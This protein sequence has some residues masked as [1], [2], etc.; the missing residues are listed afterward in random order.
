MHDASNVDRRYVRF[1]VFELD[2]ETRELRKAGARV[3]LPEQPLQVLESLL[4]RPG[5]LVTRD[6]LRQRLWPGD[7]FVDFEHG[8]NAAVKRVRDVLGD[9]ADTPRFIET[10]PRRGYRFI[11]PVAVEPVEETKG[12]APL[13]TTQGAPPPRRT[14]VFLVLGGLGLVALATG[15]AW[16][17]EAPGPAVRVV[18]LTSLNG[19]ESEPTFSPDGDQ[20]AFTWT[21]END[22]N[23]DIYVTIV[24]SSDVR[25]LTTDPGEDNVPSWSPNGQQI[26]FVRA[27][28]GGVGRVHVM[29]ALGGLDLKVAEFPVRGSIAWSP[30]G[31]YLAVSR[32]QSPNDP[33]GTTGIYL[34]PTTPGEPRA[35][36]R[37][38]VVGNL[39]GNRGPRFSPDGRH[40]AFASCPQH[41]ECYVE[42][43]DLDAGYVPTGPPRRLTQNS[44]NIVRRLAWAP[45][46][47][48]VIFDNEAGY[49]AFHLW[50]VGLD[51]AH[52]PERIE[53][54]G[55]GARSPA[56][57]PSRNRLAFVRQHYD[58]DIY[59]FE[60]GRPPALVIRSSLTDFTPV[61]SPDGRRI[62][63]CSSRSG[64]SV[65]IWVAASDGSGAQQLTHGPGRWQ[66]SP[67]WS[68]DGRRI[69]FDAREETAQHLWIIDADGGGLRRI[70][71]DQG[72]QTDA[73]WARSGWIYYSWFDGKTQDIWRTRESG[74]KPERM[75]RT[76]AGIGMES[77]DGKSLVY[78]LGLN[79]SQL[80]ERPLA[81]GS[82][83][84]LVECV[85]LKAFYSSPEGLYYVPCHASGDEV[86][87]LKRA[88][89]GRDEVVGTLGPPVG[90]HHG[91]AVS[92]DGSKILFTFTQ[93]PT[94]GADVMLIENFR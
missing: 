2:V 13:V 15:I 55:V 84:R 10:V 61:Y 26:A 89:T 52:P 41:L 74:D 7:T 30:D 54:A 32:A 71:S 44:F 60:R 92:P 91:L 51:G 27:S 73:M 83:R 69:V 75:T 58:T 86:V 23:A 63:F 48:S 90:T 46:G 43:L 79:D 29:S 11:C 66:C 80:V 76:G 9:S 40:L 21:G 81:G 16:W 22:D 93:P 12:S 3:N 62:A 94:N 39:T 70:T 64:E 57:T 65:E 56:T 50:R 5:A 82:V 49:A 85:S 77:A 42:V 20:V 87:H 53:V 45:D 59:A 35:V 78:T 19:W 28:R 37:A 72:N 34:V 14:W 18:P 24:G 17:R 1:S 33:P 36:A 6:E 88:G 38:P 47:N 25:R 4:A 68:P 8:L 67:S 31:R